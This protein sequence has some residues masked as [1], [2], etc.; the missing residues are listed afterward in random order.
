M[1]LKLKPSQ[2]DPCSAPFSPKKPNDT[3]DYALSHKHLSL[4][5]VVISLKKF[6]VPKV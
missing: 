2:H 1:E 3:L 5:T 4:S 6:Q